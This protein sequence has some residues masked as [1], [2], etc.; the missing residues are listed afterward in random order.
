MAL[1]AGSAVKDAGVD[2]MN[3]DAAAAT[4]MLPPLRSCMPAEIK[5]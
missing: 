3:S 4:W 1:A 5:K 2:V